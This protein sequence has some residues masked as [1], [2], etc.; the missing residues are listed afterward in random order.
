MAQGFSRPLIDPLAEPTARRLEPYEIRQTSRIEDMCAHLA[1]CKPA[2]GTEALRQL[3]AAYPNVP[4][5][6]RVKA[7]ESTSFNL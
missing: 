2:T 4:L 3:R 1:K 6:D 7:A 5:A